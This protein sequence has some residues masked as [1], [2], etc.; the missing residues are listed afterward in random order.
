MGAK[1]LQRMAKLNNN[2]KYTFLRPTMANILERY[3]QKFTASQPVEA[4]SPGAAAT[5]PSPA[6]APA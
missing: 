4:P 5:A 2:W 1:L 3:N 6:P